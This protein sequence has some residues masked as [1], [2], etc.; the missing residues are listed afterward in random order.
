MT[1]EAES[2]DISPGC[3]WA[4]ILRP[5]LEWTA[6]RAE[7]IAINLFA[8]LVGLALFSLF[9]MALGKSPGQLFR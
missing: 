3:D 9:I 8:I 4:A 7:P 6:R 1:V 5:A 2:V